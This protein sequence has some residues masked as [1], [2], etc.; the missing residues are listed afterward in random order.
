L[1]RALLSSEGGKEVAVMRTNIALV[2]VA[3]ALLAGC[4]GLPYS[5]PFASPDTSSKADCERSGGYW[6]ATPAVCETRR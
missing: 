6:H 5:D 4:G 1:A 3:L 2:L